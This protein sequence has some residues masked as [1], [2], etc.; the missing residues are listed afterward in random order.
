MAARERQYERYGKEICNSSV[1]FE[2]LIGS[3]P[4]TDSQQG[5]LQ[6][7][8]MKYGLSN[9]VQIKLIRLARTISD[10]RGSGLF[11]MK[12]SRKR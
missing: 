2:Q 4:L 11:L 5:R 10:M 9:R 8:S 1:P 6:D 12:Q 3:R 7:L